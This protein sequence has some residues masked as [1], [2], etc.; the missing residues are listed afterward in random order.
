MIELAAR[1]AER[2][3]FTVGAEPDRL[4]WAAAIARAHSADVSLGA[5]VNVGVDPDPA[6]ARDLVRGSAAI[7]ARF[8][9]EGSPPD[10]LSDVTRAGDR[11]D[12]R[13]LRRDEA[14]PG[15]GRPRRPRSATSSSTGLRS[16]AT[17]TT[18]AERIQGLA[19]LGIERVVVVPC[20][21]DTPPADLARSNELFATEVLLGSASSS[22]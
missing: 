4:R 18:S 1:H 6:R 7:F 13:R 9:A 10:G 22:L 11:G 12:R 16:P 15:L 17:P 19:E 3:D 2:I 20:S 5:F 14:R 21:L 8:S